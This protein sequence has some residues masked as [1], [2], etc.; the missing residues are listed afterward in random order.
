[1]ENSTCGK[2]ERHLQKNVDNC[3]I[4]IIA[5]HLEQADHLNKVDL[6]VLCIC[7]LIISY[8]KY[9]SLELGDQIEQADH[10]SRSVCIC[11]CLLIYNIR[12]EIQIS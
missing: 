1:M 2:P 4:L 3:K 6:C 9:K 5:L 11:I 10:S 8:Q 12:S 7:L